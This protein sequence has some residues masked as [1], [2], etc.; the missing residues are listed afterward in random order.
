MSLS[1]HMKDPPATVECDTPEEALVFLQLLRGQELPPLK[2]PAPPAPAEKPRRLLLSDDTKEVSPAEEIAP[3]RA[4]A[5]GR[6]LHINARKLLALVAGT[7]LDADFDYRAAAEA[8][9]IV[10]DAE[11]MGRVSYHLGQLQRAGLIEKGEKR[12]Q[13]R[14]VAGAPVEVPVSLRED[15]DAPPEATPP[16]ERKRGEVTAKILAAFDADEHAPLPALGATVYG[17]S[18]ANNVRKLK[19]MICQLVASGRLKRTGAASYKPTGRE[20]S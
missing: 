17:A 8:L 4:R 9:F 6:K 2:P 10:P 20:R 3:E 15:A 7:G 5:A 19:I 11:A 13:W 12:G 18:D 14:S 16:P 1:I